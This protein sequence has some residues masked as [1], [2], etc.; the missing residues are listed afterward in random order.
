MKSLTD[1]LNNSYRWMMLKESTI[2]EATVQKV[3][4][5]F[6]YA[7]SNNQRYVCCLQTLPV[8]IDVHKYKKAEQNI[9]MAIVTDSKRNVVD[10]AIW[11]ID[12]YLYN[13]IS[14]HDLIGCASILD[15]DAHLNKQKHNVCN[16]L[17]R[18]TP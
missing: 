14:Y 6:G 13:R 16:L 3:L 2:E 5:L 8:R 10:S 18:Y 11:N 1:S 15:I 4:R 7:S 12:S 17:M 9:L